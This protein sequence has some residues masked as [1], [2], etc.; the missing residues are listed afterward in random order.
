[1]ARASAGVTLVGALAP[2]ASAGGACDGVEQPDAA[3]HTTSVTITA[4]VLFSVITVSSCPCGHLI[5]PISVSGA[6]R[7]SSARRRSTRAVPPRHGPRYVPFDE[8]L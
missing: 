5:E 2:S 1:M 8:F 3:K 4:T 7:S 6:T